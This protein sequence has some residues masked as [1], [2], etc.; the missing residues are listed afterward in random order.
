[1]VAGIEQLARRQQKLKARIAAD[2]AELFDVEQ[3]LR[4]ELI[5][6]FPATQMLTGRQADVF[7]LIGQGQSNKEVARHLCLTVRTVKFHVSSLLK[8]FHVTS[9]QQLTAI[10]TGNGRPSTPGP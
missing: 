6:L 7:K 8:N 4:G 5:A 9:R 1:M 10:Y 3:Q 2:Q